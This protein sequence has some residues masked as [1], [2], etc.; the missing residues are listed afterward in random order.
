MTYKEL[1]YMCLDELKLISDDALFTEEH[2]LFLLNKYR[3]FLLK[4]RYSDIKK[5]IPES[6]YQT[7]CLDLTQ[8][9]AITGDLCDGGFYLRSVQKIPHLMKIGNPQIFPID[10]YQGNITYISRERMRYV[11]YNKYLRNIIYVSL[12]PDKYLYFKSINPQHLYLNKVRMIGVFEDTQEASNLQ[13]SDDADAQCDI[14]DRIFPL[15]ESL[16][17]PLI[18]LVVKELSGVEYRPNDENNNSKDDLSNVS[19]K[20]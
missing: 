17:P 4:Q 10:Y 2:V 19:T 14:Y 5:P 15:E 8:V 18:E 7:I 9:P 6:N 11:G 13:C 20:Q 1:I 12:G 3:I 16:V